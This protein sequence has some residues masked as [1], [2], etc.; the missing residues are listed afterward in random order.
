MGDEPLNS[1]RRTHPY[2][3][4]HMETWKTLLVKRQRWWWCIQWCLYNGVTRCHLGLILFLKL[5]YYHMLAGMSVWVKSACAMV[6]MQKSED[7][8]GSHLS[9]RRLSA[10]SSDTQAW[11]ASTFTHWTIVQGSE[12]GFSEAARIT[13]PTDASCNS[14]ALD[15]GMSFKGKKTPKC[16]V[17]TL[18]YPGHSFSDQTSADI[19]R[20]NQHHMIIEK[21]MS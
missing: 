14:S 17:T 6:H 9:H 12:I 5:Q 10:L 7:K 8:C 16:M 19:D 4:I 20:Q 2:T 15:L 21:L 3:P 11:T 13:L 18:R 1:Y